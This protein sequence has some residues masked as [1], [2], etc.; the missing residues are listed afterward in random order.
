MLNKTSTFFN[1]S[2]HLLK[3][4]LAS[5]VIVAS[6]ARSDILSITDGQVFDPTQFQELTLDLAARSEPESQRVG[7]RVTLPRFLNHY[8]LFVET[9]ST[10]GDWGDL[11]VN[12]DVRF[13]G[14]GTGAGIYFS[15]FPGWKNINAT[16][17][18]SYHS[19]DNNVDTP[20]VVSGRVA[21]V[22][23]AHQSVSARV[24][25]SR[26]DPIM[27]NG[28]NAYVA[29]GIIGTRSRRHIYVDQ[30]EEPRLARSDDSISG[31]LAAGLVYPINR[32]RFYAAV[33][34]QEE[35]A[36]SVGLRWNITKTAQQETLQ[37]GSGGAICYFQQILQATHV[38]KE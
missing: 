36:L 5:V 17:K 10:Q 15:G 33:E 31:Y 27:N 29:L 2:L 21:S 11:A 38:P 18:L 37:A 3:L 8:A 14:S 35:F 13:S 6:P 32:L 25:F 20:I 4:I 24:L 19:E 30:Q 22:D 1:D 9:S 28:L 23:Q 7:I 34:I 12:G 16:Y 26:A